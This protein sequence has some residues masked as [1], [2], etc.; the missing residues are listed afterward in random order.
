MAEKEIAQTPAL[1]VIGGSSGSLDALMLVL[2]RL[3]PGL[4]FPIVIVLHRS[5]TSDQALTELFASKTTLP[6]KEADEK[7]ILLPGHIYIAP[8]D[9]HLLVEADGTLSLDMG[10]KVNYSRPSIDVTVTSAAIAYRQ[11]LTAILLSGANADGVAGMQCVQE[12]RGTNIIQDPRE[13]PMPFMPGQAI[14]AGLGQ[15]IFTVTQIGDYLSPAKL[16]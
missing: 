15:H 3:S 11:K 2:P 6:V 10:E 9:Y 4:A 8:P 12:Y 13:A 14:A 1:V 7:D 5:N 16:P